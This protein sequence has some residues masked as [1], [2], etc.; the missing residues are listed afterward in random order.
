LRSL[1]G[2][3]TAKI[4]ETLFSV[5]GK[6][7]LPPINANSTPTEIYKWKALSSVKKCFDNLFKPI[8]DD[9]KDLYISRILGKVWNDYS[10]ALML[11]V[12]FAINVCYTI[13][14]PEIEYITIDESI[15]D[16][17]NKYL[18]SITKYYKI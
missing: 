16:L 13:L 2:S 6:Q 3:L 5:Y 1:R 18:V 11:H 10:N 8:N 4:K 9:I 7:N 15:M 17:V 14:N 12:A